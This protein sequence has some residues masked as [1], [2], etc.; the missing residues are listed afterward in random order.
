MG[1]TTVSSLVLRHARTSLRK[2]Q[3][4]AATSLGITQEELVEM[5]N[6]SSGTE[7]TYV[8]L[9]K[10]SRAYK[11]PLAF[12]LLNSV[13]RNLEPENDFRTLESV[14]IEDFDSKMA[15]VL[16]EAQN[17]RKKFLRLLNELEVEA[18]VTL[19]QLNPAKDVKSQ[20][21]AL[22][23]A[24][25]VD[26]DTQLRKWDNTKHT[27]ARYRWQEAIEDRG[28]LVLSHS[29]DVEEIRGFALSG[30][31]LPP[32]V[33]FNSKDDVR[34]S[35]FTIIHELA[36]VLVGNSDQ[37][38]H[39]D[40]EKFCNAVAAN[41]LVPDE[42]F[43][44]HP[45]YEKLILSV[46]SMND[47]TKSFDYWVSHIASKYIVSRHVIL[48]K[49]CDLHIISES[50]YKKKYLEYK[51]DYAALVKKK[52]EQKKKNKEAGRAGGESVAS[53]VVRNF[54]SNYVRTVLDAKNGSRIST[55]EAVEYFGR[56]KAIH[57]GGI[58]E[59]YSSRYEQ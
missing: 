33:V 54:G 9:K 14:H 21:Q 42:S 30:H 5:E 52:E 19:P 51:I 13:P 22:R 26:A 31:G 45:Y 10:L 2:S 48:R 1:K 23:D 55:Y 25:G 58:E 56:I 18:K 16:R 32:A 44:K 35:I 27:L 40:I 39:T 7:V 46:K 17:T 28:V 29:F 20:A 24:V 34:A 3:T 4:E 6:Q 37:Y 15:L 57:L 36:H 59:T 49:A 43:R 8:T 53:Q 12:F 47:N 41:F 38:T 11:R 50:F